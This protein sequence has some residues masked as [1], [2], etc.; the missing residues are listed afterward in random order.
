MIF[1]VSMLAFKLT[2]SLKGGW[3]QPL[4]LELD[5]LVSSLLLFHIHNLYRYG[6]GGQSQ[7]DVSKD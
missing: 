5:L 2:H 3:F 1:L 6:V 7:P 4:N